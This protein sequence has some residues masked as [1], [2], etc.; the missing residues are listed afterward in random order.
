M[1]YSVTRRAVR[2]SPGLD[3]FASG[4][5]RDA[6]AVVWFVV[7]ALL[8][9]WPVV[10]ERQFIPR[11]GG[12][13]VSFIYPRYVFAADAVRHGSFPLWDPYL[14]AGQPY[15]ADVQSGI[16]YPIN[17]I[18]FVLAR[19]FDYR[20]LEYLAI[21]HYALA[22]I[23]AYFW[24]RQL[25]IG[26]FGALVA[27]IVWETS[28]FLVAHLGHYN[29]LAAAV[30]VPLVLG[31]LQP[32][33]EGGSIAWVAAAAA[34]LA[35]AVFAGH[36][37]ISLYTGLLLFLYVLGFAAARRYWLAPLRSLILLGGWSV[38]LTFV[39]LL[40]SYQLTQQSVRAE[41]SYSDAT[42]FALLPQ[43][44][45]LFLVPHFYGRAPDAYWG[46]P[47]LTENYLYIGILPLV[48]AGL[49]LLCV[50]DWRPRLLAALVGL[51]LFLS[52]ADWAPLHG[53]MFALVP[54]FDKVRA[55]GRFLL[56]VDLGIAM[57]AGLGAD[58]LTRPL[59]SRRRAL[60]R[61]Y[62]GGWSLLALGLIVVAAPLVYL[63]LFLNQSQAVALVQQIQTATSSFALALVFVLASVAIL[64]AYRYRWL[65]RTLLL[66]AVVALIV[67]DLVGNNAVINPTPNDPTAGFSHPAVVSFLQQNLGAARIDTVTGVED[68]WQP[69]S[70]A[71]YRLRSLWGL[72]DPL[73]LSDY[74]W[75][76]KI[77]VP[78]RSSAL[79]DLLGAKYLLAHKNV[80]LDWNKFKLVSS[81]DPRINV[82]QDTTALPRA[83]FVGKGIAAASHDAALAAVKDKAFD[84]RVSVVV[85]GAA[86]AEAQ[87]F[88]PIPARIT[89]D[90]PNRVV[91]KVDAPRAGYL[92]LSDVYYGGWSATVDGRP[93]RLLRADWAFR[94]VPL[95][96]GQ[97]EIV[98]RFL[99]RT[100]IVAGLVSLLAWLAAASVIGWELWRVRASV[101]ARQ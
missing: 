16:L 10:F 32:A 78:G 13:L 90:G 26:R 3:L 40:P 1:D 88:G 49:A 38:L 86:V 72:Y 81:N 71:L 30:W 46:P 7:L 34:S 66:A 19:S 100:L 82:Y 25:R 96:A 4:R 54:G 29:L 64:A 63:K 27:G 48:L 80:V 85:E 15:L 23:F 44:L 43:K 24:A 61:L 92:V 31:F 42:A 33:L 60:F 35:V 84:P 73:T 68:V 9:F 101:A 47:S 74:Y 50:R 8:L 98:F 59:A 99:P 55:P 51:G 17:L 53:W 77:H 12:D 39:Q 21:L 95:A 52:F 22:G 91:V 76:W 5:A 67:V 94:A 79:Y 97:H 56:Y 2:R 41:I 45:I 36:T 20:K 93:A 70:S 87:A 75:F 65:N 83:F 69:D 28:G 37:Q 62:L 11:G 14:Y 6:V 89:V 58:L 57:L 18:A